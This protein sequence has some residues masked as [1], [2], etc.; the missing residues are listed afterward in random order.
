MG[1]GLGLGLGLA[2]GQPQ[3]KKKMDVK[4]LFIDG[5]CLRATL[6]KISERYF[7]GRT[8]K[9]DYNRLKSDH[10]KAF[11]YDAIPAIKNTETDS[12]YTARIQPRIDLHNQI[13][14][15]PGYH[16]YEGDSR[17]R[18]KQVQQKEVDVMIAV[19]MLTHTFR[20][21]M[22]RA[23][24]LAS[25]IDF[26]P[27]LDAL[28]REGMF[29]NLLYPP[30]DTNQD[31]VNAADQRTPLAIDAIYHFLDQE[32][33]GSLVLPTCGQ[34]TKSN[35]NHSES[36]IVTRTQSLGEI[37]HKMVKG[38]HTIYWEYPQNIDHLLRVEC[39]DYETLRKY[40]EDVFLVS[41]PASPP[42][43]S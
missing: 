3:R 8:L 30:T 29:V 7:D 20:G 31:L 2:S 35:V 14:T 42:S 15:L 12:E 5:G 36:T 34:E 6:R 39:H 18:R 41:I 16:I 37:R 1:F 28:V 26:K 13:A 22:D 38:N 40:L 19:D 33:R 23:T 25:D 43:G 9:I 27:L 21:N 24:F 32:S 17:I 11:Y 10:V 4:Y